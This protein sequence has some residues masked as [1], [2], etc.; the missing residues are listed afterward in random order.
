MDQRE[1]DMTVAFGG[2]EP[3]G[4]ATPVAPPFDGSAPCPA[5]PLEV[6]GLY[7]VA[8]NLLNLLDGDPQ[9]RARKLPERI[10]EF[11][12]AVAA[13]GPL[14]D[15]HFEDEAHWHRTGVR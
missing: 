2:G 15:A 7:A 10:A 8:K 6:R 5:C 3:P 13:L 12:E 1:R 9:R 4:V 11:R 14:V